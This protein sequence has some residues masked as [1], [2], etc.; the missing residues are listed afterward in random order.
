MMRRAKAPGR[1]APRV[2]P[3]RIVQEY[4]RAEALALSESWYAVY[5]RHGTGDGSR[6]MLWHVFSFDAYP[7]LEGGPADEAY[8]A[9]VAP[10]YVVLSNDRDLAF[11]TDQRP[12]AIA[13]RDAYVFPR[14]LAW[15]MAFTHE[16]G[17]MGPYFARHP[18]HARLDAANREA[19]ARRAAQARAT[20]QKQAEIE[21]ARRKGWL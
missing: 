10:E 19:V 3:G 4:G 7:S 16:D 17:W 1:G 2:E 15:T 12:T 11:V 14:N 8:A 13:L 5:G 18:D 9:C 6:R 20:A 21:A